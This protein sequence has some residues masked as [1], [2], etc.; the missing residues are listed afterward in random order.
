MKLHNYVNRII[1]MLLASLI[2]IYQKIEKKIITITNLYQQPIAHYIA[3]LF[4]KLA[5]YYF[6][7]EIKLAVY[8]INFSF[9]FF[10]DKNVSKCWSLL[11]QGSYSEYVV[12]NYRIFVVLINTK[13]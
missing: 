4:V 13:T 11:K 5:V 12:L 6:F 1:F 3:S 2:K 7:Y 8:A 9:F 10:C